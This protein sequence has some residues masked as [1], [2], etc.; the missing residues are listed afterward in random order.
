MTP[1][2]TRPL[3]LVA[4]VLSSLWTSAAHAQDL[5]PPPPIAPG[6]PSSGTSSTTSNEAD[7]SKDS[8]L[9]LEWVWL[10]GDLSLIHI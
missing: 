8:G 3:A 10:N 6:S 9:G 5:E 7:E 4:T 2:M 1:T